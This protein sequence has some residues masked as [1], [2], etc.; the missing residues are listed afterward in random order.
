[1]CSEKYRYRWH[2]ISSNNHFISS[3]FDKNF[4][5]QRK[6]VWTF[7]NLFLCNIQRGGRQD[8]IDGEQ[9]DEE[10]DEPTE[11]GLVLD[12]IGET[13]DDTV[14]DQSVEHTPQPSEKKIKRKCVQ[15]QE[16]MLVC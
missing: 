1:M 15:R 5:V 8:T 13:A 9:S 3:Y 2:P 16:R 10:K 11:A 12:E 14:E 6:R 4:Q 7:H